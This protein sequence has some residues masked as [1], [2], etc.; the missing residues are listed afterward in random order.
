VAT[1]DDEDGV[2]LNVRWVDLQLG[3]GSFDVTVTGGDGTDTL[4]MKSAMGAALSG[5]SAANY[6]KK[7]IANT[8][9]VLEITDQATTADDANLT[10]IGSNISTV[11]Y[12]AGLGDSGPSL[13]QGGSKRI[14]AVSWGNECFKARPRASNSLLLSTGSSENPGVVRVPG[15]VGE[16]YP[17]S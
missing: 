1:S 16:G 3:N 15:N 11:K 13:Y 4:A 14:N 6:A 12:T 7:G 10:R 2:I 17:R 5:L 8:F 9:E